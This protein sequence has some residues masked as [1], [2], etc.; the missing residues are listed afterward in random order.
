MMIM[1]TI[2][3]NLDALTTDD[4]LGSLERISSTFLEPPVCLDLIEDDLNELLGLIPTYINSER[5]RS[6]ENKNEH[7]QSNGAR[8]RKQRRLKEVVDAGDDKLAKMTDFLRTSLQKL[9]LQKLNVSVPGEDPTETRSG[10]VL[11]LTS[12]NNVASPA[13]MCT[14]DGTSCATY[15]P[16]GLR[17]AGDQ[18]QFGIAMVS[19]YTF[20]T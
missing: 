4:L 20:S 14:E 1:D 6:R 9:N 13:S 7:K 15:P 11:R 10:D 5:L 18:R 8:S 2:Q 17:C 3:S 12:T 16:N 19:E